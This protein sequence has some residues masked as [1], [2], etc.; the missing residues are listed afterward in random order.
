MT[1]ETKIEDGVYFLH[2]DGSAWIAAEFRH[3]K[4][5]SMTEESNAWVGMHPSDG[6]GEVDTDMAVAIVAEVMP[7][8]DPLLVAVTVMS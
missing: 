4:L 1:T 2:P 8:S 3:G 7:D 6:D 5:A